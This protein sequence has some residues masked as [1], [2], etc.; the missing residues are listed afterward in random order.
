MCVPGVFQTKPT[1]M[2]L[3][4]FE[5]DVSEGMIFRRENEN[6]LSASRSNAIEVNLENADRVA[7]MYKNYRWLKTDS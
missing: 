7:I 3:I 4:W 1:D 5:Q 2:F 6:L